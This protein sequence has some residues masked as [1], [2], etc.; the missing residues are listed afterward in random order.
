MRFAEESATGARRQGRARRGALSEA[1]LSIADLERANVEA[2]ASRAARVVAL[3]ASVN[4]SRAVE[5]VR[6]LQRRMK[7]YGN[8]HEV[9]RFNVRAGEMLGLAA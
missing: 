8:L 9:Q 5:T 7:P 3:A 4:S 1:A 2:A 6:D